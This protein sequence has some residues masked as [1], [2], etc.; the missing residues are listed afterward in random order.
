[1]EDLPPARSEVDRLEAEIEDMHRRRIK[2]AI[3]E[4]LREHPREI[5][6]AALE[7]IKQFRDDT[8]REI[9]RRIRNIFGVLAVLVLLGL[10]GIGYYWR[11][12]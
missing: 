11:H 8:D 4:L 1:M 7:I 9:G 3:L 5:Y 6:A 12:W 10:I 2:A